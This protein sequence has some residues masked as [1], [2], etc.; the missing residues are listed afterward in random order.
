[1]GSGSYGPLGSWVSKCTGYTAREQGFLLEIDVTGKGGI[2]GTLCQGLLVLI[3]TRRL[4]MEDRNMRVSPW[5]HRTLY[6][7]SLMP[8]ISVGRAREPRVS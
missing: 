5:A 3:K 7:F 1:M 2:R 4:E 6:L 8:L